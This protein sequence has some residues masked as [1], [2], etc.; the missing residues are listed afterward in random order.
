[1]EGVRNKI[2]VACEAPTESLMPN[3]T[4]RFCETGRERVEYRLV[5]TPNIFAVYKLGVVIQINGDNP[6]AYT[7]L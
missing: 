1:M 3:T 7:V 5:L 2:C 6:P 4:V